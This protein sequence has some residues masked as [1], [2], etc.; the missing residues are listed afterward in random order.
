MLFFVLIPCTGANSCLA[1]LPLLRRSSFLLRPSSGEDMSSPKAVE[2]ATESEPTLVSDAGAP[3]RAPADPQ[4]PKENKKDCT[5]KCPL[6][7]NMTPTL[8]ISGIVLVIT[9]VVMVV[10][11]K[12][13]ESKA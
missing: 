5:G 12:M 7:Q 4:Q 8:L 13:R 1:H 11:K 10:T 6:R 3:T 9:G 2:G